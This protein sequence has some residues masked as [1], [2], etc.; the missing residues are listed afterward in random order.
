MTGID[1]PY[2]PPQPPDVRVTEDMTVAAAVDAV[3]ALL[4]TNQKGTSA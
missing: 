1:D 2:E 3:L 4:P